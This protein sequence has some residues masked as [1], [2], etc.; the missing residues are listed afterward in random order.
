MKS[1]PVLLPNGTS[2]VNEVLQVRRNRPFDPNLTE[3]GSAGSMWSTRAFW[4][5]WVVVCGIIHSIAGNEPGAIRFQA[6][7][8]PVG[9]RYGPGQLKSAAKAAPAAV[10]S[11][12]ARATV[13]GVIRPAGPDTDTANCAR[14]PGTAT[15]THR[16][17][18][19]CSPSS[20]A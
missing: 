19:S 4:A 6:P 10:N 7:G 12:T 9:G 14:T 13:S 5:E 11:G 3:N 16:T 15:A 8:L 1:R 18:S 20:M 2:E 17:P